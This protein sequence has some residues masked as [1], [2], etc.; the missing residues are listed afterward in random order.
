MHCIITV[1]TIYLNIHSVATLLGT[2]VQCN[3]TQYNCSA[4]AIMYIVFITHTYN[5]TITLY[6]LCKRLPELEHWISFTQVFA[7][8]TYIIKGIVMYILHITCIYYVFLILF[9]VI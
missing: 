1:K 2:Y 3:A 8:V 9:L 4:C 7:Q 5:Y 6:I